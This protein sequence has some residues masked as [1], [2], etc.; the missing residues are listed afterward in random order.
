ML[1]TKTR[2]RLVAKVQSG[3]SIL[4]SAK[5]LHIRPST[6]KRIVRRFKETAT[7]Y[8][9]GEMKR[10]REEK[11]RRCEEGTKPFITPIYSKRVGRVAGESLELEEIPGIKEMEERPYLPQTIQSSAYYDWLVSSWA[12]MSWLGVPYPIYPLQ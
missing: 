2:K 5:E 6:A 1:V 8:E 10:N 12:Q 7:F 4:S 3:K 9:S 11:E